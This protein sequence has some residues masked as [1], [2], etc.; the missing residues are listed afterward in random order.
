M[1]RGGQRRYSAGLVENRHTEREA[2]G[3]P[4]SRRSSG[5]GAGRVRRQA[6]SAVARRAWRRGSPAARPLARHL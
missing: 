4:G 3:E 5:R 6:H 1:P 2:R